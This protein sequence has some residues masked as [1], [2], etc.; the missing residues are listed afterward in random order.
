MNL[1]S[2][3]QGIE[4]SEADAMRQ[5]FGKEISE[6]VERIRR[7]LLII[8]FITVAYKLSGAQFS[9]QSII[10]GIS[11]T[12]VKPQSLEIGLLV[13]LIYLLVHFIWAGWEEYDKWRIR[14][15]TLFD[16]RPVGTTF[17]AQLNEKKVKVHHHTLYNWW[18]YEFK[19]VQE[20]LDWFASTKQ[21]LKELEETIKKCSK[22]GTES[23]AHDIAG[24]LHTLEIKLDNS[25]FPYE[26]FLIDRNKLDGP[27]KKFDE[28][29]WRQQKSWYWR[30]VVIE[31]GLPIIVAFIG[32]G[33]LVRGMF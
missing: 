19:F 23:N 12:G 24:K 31:A 11:F 5:P 16:L 20:K 3:E 7:N 9:D 33:L 30:W 27:L 29:F 15:T 6:Y 1:V 8:G 25:S 22:H 18:L 2:D 10:F 26:P 13:L 14:F 17:D 4:T 21:R 32:I 28:C